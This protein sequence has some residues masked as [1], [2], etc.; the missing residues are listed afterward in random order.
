[1]TKY[2]KLAAKYMFIFVINILKVHILHSP[3]RT[4]NFEFLLQKSTTFSKLKN[5]YTF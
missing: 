2:L 4:K 5:K 1:M 3:T